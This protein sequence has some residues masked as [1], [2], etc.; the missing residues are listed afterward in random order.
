MIFVTIILR[1][2]LFITGLLLM[3]SAGW[4]WWARQ[5]PPSATWLVYETVREGQ[6]EIA[7]VNI[8]GTGLRML[9][10]HPANDFSPVPSPD[11][12]WIAFVSERGGDPDIYRAPVDGGAIE[13][14]TDFFLGDWHPDWS[15]DGRHIVLTGYY[16]SNHA[17]LYRLALD[18]P[19]SIPIR[20]TNNPASDYSAAWSPDGVW[21]AFTSMRNQNVDLYLIPAEPPPPGVGLPPAPRRLTEHPGDDFTPVWSPDGEWLAFA[22]YRDDGLHIYRMRPED[23]EASVQRLTHGSS[24]NMQPAWSPDGAWLAFTSRRSGAWDLYRMRPDGRDV[25]RITH[26]IYEDKK[27]RWAPPRDEPYRLGWHILSGGLLLL[28][29]LVW[30]R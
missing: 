15:P 24:I 2:A 26:D 30:R 9:S 25:Q 29:G 7:R 22:S 3:L 16:Q 23:G 12:Q 19:P 4:L 20:M 11:G 27:P 8:D 13:N 6:R 5:A 10:P 17:E 28:L 1:C 18:G 21:L 14:L